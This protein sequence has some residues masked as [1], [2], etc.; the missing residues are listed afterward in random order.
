MNLNTKYYNI[1]LITM[2]GAFDFTG[3]Q[4]EN[5]LDIIF[6]KTHKPNDNYDK[7]QNPHHLKSWN[8]NTKNFKKYTQHQPRH[9]GT[10]HSSVRRYR[11]W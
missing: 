1:Q 6:E 8:K 5:I 10:N 9:R 7:T 4:Q 11:T 3:F 2:S